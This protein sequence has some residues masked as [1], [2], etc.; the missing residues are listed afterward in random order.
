MG[1]RRL[2][3]SFIPQ[4]VRG[5]CIVSW[6]P[7]QCAIASRPSD[8]KSFPIHL[9]LLNLW[10]WNIY[11]LTI[12]SEIGIKRVEAVL[13]EYALDRIENILLTDLLA[14]PPREKPNGSQ[15]RASCKETQTWNV[16]Q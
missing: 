2:L 12:R 4:Q 10:R 11:H 3:L 6:T 16:L 15:R 13:A 9:N 1:G 5:R 14:I 8:T 7:Q